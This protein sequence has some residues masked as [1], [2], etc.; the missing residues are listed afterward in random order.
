MSIPKMAQFCHTCG[1]DVAGDENG[2]RD[3]RR[4]TP[5]PDYVMERVESARE[6]VNEWQC[7]KCDKI[8]DYG[9]SWPGNW[10]TSADTWCEKFGGY[11]QMVKVD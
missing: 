1:E 10:G 11:V 7:P 4:C 6:P 2:P 3:H 9:D 8:V 5:N